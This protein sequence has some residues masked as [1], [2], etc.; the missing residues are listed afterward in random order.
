M[1]P[2]VLGPQPTGVLIGGIAGLE[3]GG[4]MAG[5]FGTFHFGVYSTPK[6]PRAPKEVVL[7]ESEQEALKHAKFLMYNRAHVSVISLEGSFLGHEIA[8][9]TE[10]KPRLVKVKKQ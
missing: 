7:F 6:D 5:W 10:H 9:S 1:P 2:I 4:N 3:V 8:R